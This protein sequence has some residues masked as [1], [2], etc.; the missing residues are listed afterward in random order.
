MVRH[1]RVMK[2]EWSNSRTPPL[3]A[4]HAGLSIPSVHNNVSS[5]SEVSISL[6]CQETVVFVPWTATVGTGL[7]RVH[8]EYH[9]SRYVN[10]SAR[11]HIIAQ[12][13]QC[14]VQYKGSK[15]VV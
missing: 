4:C 3:H 6:D 8:M 7:E 13:N 15:R 9:S 12:Y 2:V 5:Y 1:E 10:T 11:T 14:V